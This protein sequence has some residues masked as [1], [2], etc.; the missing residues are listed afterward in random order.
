MEPDTETS[1]LVL[2]KLAALIERGSA[3]ISKAA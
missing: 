3:Q 1:E 2:K